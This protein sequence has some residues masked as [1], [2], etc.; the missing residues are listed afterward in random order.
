MED[1]KST[2]YAVLGKRKL[3]Q[4]KYTFSQGSK[5]RQRFLCQVMVDGISYVGFGNST[6]KKD[7]QSNAARDFGQFLV[8]EG[9]VTA[10]ELPQ[11]QVQPSDLEATNLQYQMDVKEGTSAP[12]PH[13]VDFT[14]DD[15]LTGKP[16]FQRPK[17]FHDQ[18]I[19]QKAEEISQSEAV[20]MTS[21]IHGGWTMDNCKQALNEFCQK[22][23]FLPREYKTSRDGTNNSSTFVAENELFLPRLNRTIYGRGQGSTKKIA[24]ATCA[25]SIVRQLFHI[26]AIPSSSDKLSPTKNRKADNLAEIKVHVDPGLVARIE[27]YLGDVG[28]EPVVDGLEQTT[29]DAP[30]S[31]LVDKKLDE[32]PPSEDN[33]S[34]ASIMWAPPCQNWN[35]WKASNIDNQPIAFWSMDRISDDLMMREKAKQVSQQLVQARQRLPVFNHREQIIRAVNEHPVVLIKGSTGCGK[36]TQICQYLLESHLLDKRG[37]NFNC[38]VTQPRRISAI[39]LAERVANERCEQLG[40]SIGYSVRFEGITPRQ[41]GAIMFVTVGVLMRKMEMGLRGISHVIVDEIHE[42]DINTDF[43]LIVVRDMLRANPK[44]RVLLMSATIDTS[45]FTNYFGRCPIIEIEQRVHPVRGFFLEDVISM[46]KYMPQLPEPDKKKKKKR[47]GKPEP[48]ASNAD[49]DEEC[50]EMSMSVTDNLLVC[51]D[52]YPP[53]TKQALGRI[54]EREIP[55]ELI[56]QLL[57]DIDQN[58][59]PGSVLIFLPGLFFYIFKEQLFFK[60]W[61]MISLLWNRLMLHRIFSNSRRFVILPLHSQLSAR[62]QHRVFEPVGIEQRKI[63]LSTNIAETSVTIDDVVYVIDSCRVREK[64][65]SSRNNMVHFANVWASRTNLIQRRGRAGRV[66]EGFC[67][68]LVTR[69]R[70]DALE[71]HR[72]AEMLRTPLHE[73][74]LTIKLLH[75][76]SVGEFLEKAVQPPPI[77]AVVEAEVLLREMN[78]LDKDLELTDLGRILARLPIEPKLGKMVLLGA[79]M[80]VAAATSFNTPFVPKERMH[81]K[82]AHSHRSFSGNRPS[83]H[84]GLVNVN[85]QFS[86]QF[87]IDVSS[88]EDL[89]RRFSLSYP[90]LCMTREAKRQLYDV[91][92][93]HSGFPE[94][95]FTSYSIDVRGPD[96]NLDVFLS[97]LVA[98]YYP[99]RELFNFRRDRR[100]VYTLEQAVALLSNMSVC[101]PFNR[102]EQ[103]NFASPLFMFSEKLRTNCIS[104][105]QVSMISPL[106]LL[107]FGSRRVEA[108]GAD[109]VRLDNMIPLNLSAKMA[110]KIVALRPCIEALVVRSCMHPEQLSDQPK[111]DKILTAL[112]RELSSDRAW[113]PSGEEGLEPVEQSSSSKA[114]AHQFNV[115]EQRSYATPLNQ[116]L[117]LSSSAPVPLRSLKRPYGSPPSIVDVYGN[118]PSPLTQPNS[119]GQEA[120]AAATGLASSADFGGRRTPYTANAP[121]GGDYSSMAGYGCDYGPSPYYGNPQN[122][123]NQLPQGLQQFNGMNGRG[124]RGFGGRGRG[125]GGGGGGGRR[126]GGFRRRQGN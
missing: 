120:V 79:A 38:Y 72:T 69:A 26:G 96:S 94:S 66:Q 32:F 108:I 122:Q 71:D 4:P 124:M 91:L 31:L 109:K 41:Y 75:L 92:V 118:Q 9:L 78:A 28:V 8:R 2:L 27:K 68:H 54:T 58:G 19:E 98:A 52:D 115:N 110:A 63:I 67:F 106:Q 6:S 16:D 88:A 48:S 70:F 42:R 74:T 29:P 57:S 40:E 5:G 97:M 36:S 46:L 102:G 111:Q 82:L 89:C 11:L 77:D 65:Y 125:H 83:D 18:Y 30:K 81:T 85:Q 113:I 22:N 50:D 116:T 107:L 34:N 95:V 10:Q 51:N 12:L 37:A 47:S 56:E 62:E 93:N 13:H 61:Q 117:N 49:V 119:L 43:L 73:I 80:G 21:E 76:G 121:S 126:H 64:M 100:R 53:E 87:D 3:G 112:I 105:K 33:Y 101:V 20:D 25:L 123:Q 45:L 15:M 7:A 103:A 35:P 104:C 55:I 86:E 17:T 39:T 90:L 44:L 114:N 59:K 24:E 23:R 84:I 99:N 1:I 60:G 14:N